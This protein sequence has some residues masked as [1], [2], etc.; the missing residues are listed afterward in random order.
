MMNHALLFLL[1]QRLSGR[2][3]HA[4]LAYPFASPIWSL[5]RAD[6]KVE[7]LLK[8]LKQYDA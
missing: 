7:S 6:A 4:R 8:A 1:A 2:L 3:F 5:A